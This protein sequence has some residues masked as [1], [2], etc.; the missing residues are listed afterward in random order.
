MKSIMNHTI[1]E[2][3]EKDYKIFT[4]HE[5]QHVGWVDINKYLAE[6]AKDLLSTCSPKEW[7]K[8][9]KENFLD[10]LDRDY[11]RYYSFGI[12]PNAFLSNYIDHLRITLKNSK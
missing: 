4:S 9:S 2:R 3:L 1:K 10:M 5:D 12:Q 8:T 6:Y 11:N 7:T